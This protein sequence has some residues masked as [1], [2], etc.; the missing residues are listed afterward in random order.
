MLS[1]DDLTPPAGVIATLSIMG[2]VGDILLARAAQTSFNKSRQALMAC[3][4]ISS[5]E[6]LIVVAVLLATRTASHEGFS[7][8]LRYPWLLTI[9]FQSVLYHTVEIALYRCTWAPVM[10][11]LSNMA[12]LILLAPTT[13]L[14]GVEFRPLPALVFLLGLI[15]TF[16]CSMDPETLLQQLPWLQTRQATSEAMGKEIR[17][18]GNAGGGLEGTN[19]DEESALIASGG[20]SVEGGDEGTEEAASGTLSPWTQWILAM[21]EFNVVMALAI[22]IAFWQ[23]IQR[24]S[25]EYGIA[26]F[27]FLIIDQLVGGVFMMIMHILIDNSSASVQN[28]FLSEQDQSET[29]CECM[30]SIFWNQEESKAEGLTLVTVGKGLA[31]IRVV[32]AF[33]LVITYNLSAVFYSITSLRMVA[34][35]FVT[36]A[37]AFRAGSIGC[38]DFTHP[39]THL[40][41]AKC[42]GVV[43]VCFSFVVLQLDISGKVF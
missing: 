30:K 26:Q 10:K 19:P 4:V 12:A 37:L 28:F 14:F 25:S 24:A 6:C 16:L 36:S 1:A 27:S 33:Y 39:N 8:L 23:V 15:G 2:V 34:A 20:S 11:P 35:F 29:L 13:W 40:F 43:F 42:I 18:R 3:T 5:L 7:D 32:W 9:G 21:W 38:C 31:N 22:C 17:D 41:I